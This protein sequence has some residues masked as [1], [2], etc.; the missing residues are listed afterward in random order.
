MGCDEIGQV[1]IR[2]G[3]T[4]A[5]VAFFPDRY[6]EYVVPAVCAILTGHPVP[7]YIFVEN[8]VITKENID[9]WYPKKMIF[10]DMLSRGKGTEFI[11]ESIDFDTEILDYKL[12][13]A[14][15]RK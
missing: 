8:E 4:D 5:A 9:R 10:K 11:I 3:L 14:A 2:Q 7:P 6:G 15:L 1:Q 12:T 13:K